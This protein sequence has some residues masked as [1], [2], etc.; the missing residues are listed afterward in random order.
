MA[1]CLKLGL[2]AMYL[3]VLLYCH[4]QLSCHPGA[5]CMACFVGTLVLTPGCHDL[6]NPHENT[7]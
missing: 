6:P 5:V 1:W 3:I 7:G 2:T 4:H